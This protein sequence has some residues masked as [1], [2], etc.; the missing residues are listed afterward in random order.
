M[1]NK[2]IFAIILILL[3]QSSCGSFVASVLLGVKP[4]SAKSRAEI[5]SYAKT[6]DFSPVYIAKH[7]FLAELAAQNN[8]APGNFHPIQFKCFD[9]KTGEALSRYVSC[10][11]PLKK[12]GTL[13]S[14]PPLSLEEN[15]SRY[16]L[17]EELENYESFDGKKAT[18]SPSANYVIVHYWGTFTGKPSRNIQKKLL[19][20]CKRHENKKVQLISVNVLELE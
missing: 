4:P 18:I 6:H 10:E 19:D 12:L 1:K 5:E 14:F 13:E 17:F 16:N 11:A 15:L 7:D 8:Y 2:F 20:Y 9:T 3:S